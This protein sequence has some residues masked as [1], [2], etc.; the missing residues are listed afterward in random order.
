MKPTLLL[1]ELEAEVMRV[2]WDEGR[3]TVKDVAARLSRARAYNTVQTTLE[4]LYRK[5][6][7]AREKESHA[8]VY[9]PRVDRREYHRSVLSTLV[10]QLLPGGPEPVLAA[11]VEL[12]A[13]DDPENLERLEGLIAAKRRTDGGRK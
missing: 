8:F 3:V 6:L 12:A 9:S 1:G 5:A 13:D 10:G 7:L 2:A 11:F 4:R